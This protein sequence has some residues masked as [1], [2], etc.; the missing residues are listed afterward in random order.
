M[1][2]HNSFLTKVLIAHR[3]VHGINFPENSLAAF[4]RAMDYGFAIELDVHMLHDGT[5]VVIHDDILDRTTNRKGRVFDLK[6]SQ[7]KTTYLENTTETLPTLKQ[8]LTLV[9]GR[10]PLLVEIKNNGKSGPVEEAIYQM[11]K[12]YDGEYAVQSFNPFSLKWFAVNAPEVLRGQLSGYFKKEK[13]LSPIKRY[14]LRSMVLNKRVSRPHFLSYDYK[15]LP[16]KY[17]RKFADIPVLAYTITKQ[18]TFNRVKKYAHSII[19]D[20]F[21]PMHQ[22]AVTTTIVRKSKAIKYKKF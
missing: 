8:V 17:T 6:K 16:N 20:K 14:I 3:G 22:G 10:V 11:L 9:N 18:S 21:V 19:F 1:D 12:N 4:K 13:Q 2:A 15:Y 7:L 5:L